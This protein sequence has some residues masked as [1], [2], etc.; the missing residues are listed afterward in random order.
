MNFESKQMN[1]E[2]LTPKA[3]PRVTFE[4]LTPRILSYAPSHTRG[5]W[6]R[7]RTRGTFETHQL[8]HATTCSCSSLFGRPSNQQKLFPPFSAS[9]RVSVRR[10]FRPEAFHKTRLKSAD[11]HRVDR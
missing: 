4:A 9:C 5:S 11:P 7:T 2:G 10:E 8:Y 1:L 6:G 3:W